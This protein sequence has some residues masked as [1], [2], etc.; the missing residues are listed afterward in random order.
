MNEKSN[1]TSVCQN[2]DDDDDVTDD[3][4]RGQPRVWL[5]PIHQIISLQLNFRKT[6][7]VKK[8]TVEYKNLKS[9]QSNY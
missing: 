7:K 9:D 1:R 2:V 6:R 8:I 3:G 5:W 4:G